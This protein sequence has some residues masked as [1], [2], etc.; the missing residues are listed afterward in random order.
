MSLTTPSLRSLLRRA[1]RQREAVLDPADMGT[2]FGLEMTLD[3]PPPLAATPEVANM[4]RHWWR[5]RPA[6]K[7]VGA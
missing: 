4:S 1:P 2:C 7:P 6:T 5:R 3:E